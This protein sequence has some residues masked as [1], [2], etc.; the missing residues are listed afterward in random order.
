MT[1]RQRY[2]FPT[3]SQ[4]ERISA[5]PA[6]FWSWNNPLIHP[7]LQGNNNTAADLGTNLHKCIEWGFVH[8]PMRV[9][10]TEAGSSSHWWN[11]SMAIEKS[12]ELDVSDWFQ[13]SID[14]I[15]KTFKRINATQMI[16]PNVPEDSWYW[17]D[18]LGFFVEQAFGMS[19]GYA[20][21]PTLF[22]GAKNPYDR[23]DTILA[24]RAD[25]FCYNDNIRNIVDWKFGSNP[26]AQIQENLQLV[27]LAVMSLTDYNPEAPASYYSQ[28]NARLVI[29]YPVLQEIDVFECDMSYL[30]KVFRSKVEPILG[31]RRLPRAGIVNPGDHCVYCPRKHVCGALS[32]LGL[33]LAT[34]IKE[35]L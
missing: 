10:Q 29:S 8:N 25:L 33:G 1:S 34:H 30:V 19:L 24:G 17:N 31:Q 16:T 9:H 12:F 21:F 7:A 15:D 35:A 5:C 2:P 3:S 13:D 20:N 27:S 23:S 18:N 6:S 22:R 4:L 11:R 14:V 28:Y 32:S 26:V